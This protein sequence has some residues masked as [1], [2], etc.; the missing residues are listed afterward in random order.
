MF[1]R[2]KRFFKAFF[3]RSRRQVTVR[4]VH[5]SQQEQSRDLPPHFIPIETI[6]E[7]SAIP[8]TNEW[9]GD[10]AKVLQTLQG[11]QVTWERK[12][13]IQADCGHMIFGIHEEITETG[14]QRG[15]GG[16]C[17]YCRAESEDTL[18]L[19]CSQCTS[20]CDNCGKHN[21][22]VRHTR[23]FEDAAGQKRLLCPDCLAKAELDKFF[24]KTVLTLLWP[25]LD[26]NRTRNSEK[27]KNHYEY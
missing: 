18:G 16:I 5:H 14:I 24:K 13:G 1:E 12:K 23:L 15:L 19:Y 22:C 2:I 20:H 25:F 17:D 11:E 27:G 21:I 9:I 6:T 10:I 7:G 3:R 26:H 8:G 4:Q